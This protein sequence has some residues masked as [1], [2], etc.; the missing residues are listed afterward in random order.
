MPMMKTST[1]FYFFDN[2]EHQT[3]LFIETDRF[4]DESFDDFEKTIEL[5]D[6]LDFEPSS[7][8]VEFILSYSGK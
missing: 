2:R 5:L 8:A 4:I 1:F 3:E 6:L 7:K